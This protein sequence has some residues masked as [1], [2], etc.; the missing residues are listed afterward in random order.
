MSNK[1]KGSLITESSV[2][3][4]ILSNKEVQETVARAISCTSLEL[5]EFLSQRV[6][7]T[8][9]LSFYTDGGARGNPGISGCGVVVDDGSVK[10]GYFY[11][12]GIQTNNFAEY[13][14][15]LK[16]L[17]IAKEM[18]AEEVV[19]YSDSEL[20]CKQITGEYKVK[21]PQL[22]ILYKEA[23]LY[24]YN[25]K[26][27]KIKHVRREFN[28]DADLLA[29]MAMDEKRNGEVEFTTAIS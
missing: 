16:A 29:N 25:L 5:E 11:Y 3:K 8:K 27:F 13:T 18:N 2:F 15:L 12:L 19:V 26:S 6:C 28:K 17:S 1:E 14:G 23:M 20:M 22:G 21:S 4:A 24:I 7:T 9:K 10:K